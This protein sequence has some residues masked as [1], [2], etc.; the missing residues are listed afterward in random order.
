M[1]ILSLPSPAWNVADDVGHI[2]IG[3][4]NARFLPCCGLNRRVDVAGS[5]YQD[6]LQRRREYLLTLFHGRARDIAICA[7]RSKTAER[8]RRDRPHTVLE[9]LE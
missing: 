3:Y 2:L 8:P 1:K 5:C 9:K 7:R 4:H 6:F